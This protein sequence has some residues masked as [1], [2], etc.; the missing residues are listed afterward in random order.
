[1]RIK[2]PERKYP[3]I[4]VGKQKHGDLYYIAHS[5]EG[6]YSAA[7][8]LVKFRKEND[9]CYQAKDVA[10]TFEEFFAEKSGGQTVE[11]FEKMKA[12]LGEQSSNVMFLNSNIKVDDYMDF[13]KRQY[14]SALL[15]KK[16]HDNVNK[17]I[18]EN[19]G[20]LALYVLHLNS[21]NTYEGIEIEQDIPEF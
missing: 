8:E 6:L 20:K 12:V 5:E 11:E 7:L 18:D 15:D 3:V 9:M 16:I 10:D 4:L 1:M 13:R 21:D 17:A 2:K 19:N 14:R